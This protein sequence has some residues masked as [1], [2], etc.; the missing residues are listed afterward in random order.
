MPSPKNIIKLSASDTSESMISKINYNFM[1]ILNAVEKLSKPHADNSGLLYYRTLNGMK[2]NTDNPTCSYVDP[3]HIVRYPFG[4]MEAWC[5]IDIQNPLIN[6]FPDAF[7]FSEQNIDISSLGFINDD[8]CILATIKAEDSW[9]GAKVGNFDTSNVK[10][11]I[12]SHYAV[13]PSSGFKINI[14]LSGQWR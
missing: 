9:F 7:W 11:Y 10:L 2:S 14:R 1:A 13:H 3:W 6:E 4:F 8:I 5:S 12:M